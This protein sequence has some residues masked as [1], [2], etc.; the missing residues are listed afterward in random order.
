MSGSYVSFTDGGGAAQL[1]NGTTAVAGGAGSRFQGWTSWAEPIGPSRNALGTGALYQF[2]FRT[3]YRAKFT[4]HDIPNANVTIIDRLIAF[5][6]GGGVVA[7]YTGDSA[8]NSYTNCCLAPGS[9]PT[10]EMTSAPDIYW[11][12]TLELVN[13]SGAAMTCLY[14]S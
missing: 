10:K 7:V 4:I 5:L 12:V 14:S 1:D 9:R 2:A 11:N 13:L 6:L 3:D 8:G